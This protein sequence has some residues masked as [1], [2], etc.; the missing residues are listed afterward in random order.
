MLIIDR[1]EGRTAV[2]ETDTGHENIPLDSIKG[3]PRE[4]DVLIET[5]GF[6]EIDRTETEN[7]RKK[8]AERSKKLWK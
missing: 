7:R 8:I 3:E 2:A 1:I 5:N 4:G 6:F